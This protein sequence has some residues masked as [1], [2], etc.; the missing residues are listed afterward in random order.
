[1]NMVVFNGYVSLNMGVNNLNF[2]GGGFLPFWDI[3]HWIWSSDVFSGWER[4]EV[5]QTTWVGESDWKRD[6]CWIRQL[7]INQQP[8]WML[9]LHTTTNL[10]HIIW[11]LLSGAFP[12]SSAVVWHMNPPIL[13]PLNHRSSRHRLCGYTTSS[14]FLPLA[15]W[16][17]NV[18][19]G[20][21]VH[22]V[23][24]SMVPGFKQ[25]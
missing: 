1:M 10:Q 6:L 16:D 7:R 17:V 5:F 22:G 18:S 11:A 14:G 24:Y 12:C 4:L 3:V 2:D 20:W 9:S 8:K 19:N 25:I 21:G 23:L 13:G 15:K